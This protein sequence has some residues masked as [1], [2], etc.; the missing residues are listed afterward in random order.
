MCIGELYYLRMILSVGAR[1]DVGG[2]VSKEFEERDK[3]EI[4]TCHNKVT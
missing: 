1:E 4:P 2:E 3:K